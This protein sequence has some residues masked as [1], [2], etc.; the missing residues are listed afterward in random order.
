MGS[1]HPLPPAADAEPADLFDIDVLVVGAGPAGVQAALAAAGQGQRVLVVDSAGTAAAPA[2][3]DLAPAARLRSVVWLARHSALELLLDAQGAVRGAAGISHSGRAAD[4]VERPW[5]ALAGAVVLATGQ[6]LLMAAEAGALLGGMDGGMDRRGDDA[7]AAGAVPRPGGL[8]LRDVGG[9][10]TVPGLFAAGRAAWTGTGLPTHTTA[11]AL[12]TGQQA[13]LSA[14]AEARRVASA[15]LQ[16]GHGA[17]A[18]LRPAG[19]VGLR[20]PGQQPISPQ[21]ACAALQA[22]LAPSDP[23]G[24]APLAV[25]RRLDALWQFLRHA[26]PAPSGA[27]RA[28][29]EAA[30]R[31]AEARWRLHSRIAR[32]RSPAR[33]HGIVTGGLDQVWAETEA[34]VWPVVMDDQDAPGAAVA[35]IKLAPIQPTASPRAVLRRLAAAGR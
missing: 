34:S 6:G 9:A 19:Q 28:T 3:A 13:G 20:G 1:L 25:M 32:A 14:A 16:A 11:G 18:A 26:A 12:F 4:S 33:H 23:T 35:A 8:R 21:A 10:T 24:S 2:D 15:T 30:A 22:V 5:R 7:R 17:Q 27:L 31:L 29:R